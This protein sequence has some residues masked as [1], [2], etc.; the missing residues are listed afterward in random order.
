[1]PTNNQ[2]AAVDSQPTDNTPSAITNWHNLYAGLDGLDGR[3]DPQQAQAIKLLDSDPNPQEARARVIN[4]NRLSEQLK[5]MDPEM[6]RNNWQ[7]VKDAYVKHAFGSNLK[8]VDDVTLYNMIAEQMKAERAPKQGQEEQSYG[9]IRSPT[10]WEKISNGFDL[11]T[12]NLFHPA[13]KP[14]MIHAE[15][16]KSD[17]SDI[18]DLLGNMVGQTVLNPGNVLTGAMLTEVNVAGSARRVLPEA[19]HAALRRFFTAQMIGQT[20]IAA[21]GVTKEWMNPN[22]SGAQAT[23][24][25]IGLAVGGVM[26][27][28]GV[29]AEFVPKEASVPVVQGIKD[30]PAREAANSV[31]SYASQT[32]TPE[33]QMAF[34]VTADNFHEMDPTP[35]VEPKPVA[36]HAEPLGQIMVEM[37]QRIDSGEAAR[38]GELN[39]PVPAGEQPIVQPTQEMA[40]QMVPNETPAESTSGGTQIQESRVVAEPT[41]SE[42]KI[43][44]EE[45]SKRATAKSAIGEDP[46]TLKQRINANLGQMA[47]TMDTKASLRE[48]YKG[49]EKA[50]N[51]ALKEGIK[52]GKEAAYKDII[53]SQK[54]TVKQII[55]NNLNQIS[56]MMN[57]KLAMKE[58]YKGQEL[59]ARK[60]EVFTAEKYREMDAQSRADAE[61]IKKSLVETV[62]ELP[63]SE[64]GKF[65]QM[66]ADTIRRPAIGRDPEGLYR[67][68][69]QT[70]F[71]ILNHLEYV[72]KNMLIDDLRDSIN[73]SLESKQIDVTYKKRIEDV[74][75]RITF[76]NLQDTTKNR[77]QGTLD[78]IKGK[79]EEHGVPN[80]V[81]NQVEQLFKIPAKD[82]PVNVLEGMQD[83]VELLANLGKANLKSRKL[84]YDFEKNEWTDVLKKGESTPFNSAVKEVAPGQDLSFAE[85]FR[86]NAGNKLRKAGEVASQLDI[87]LLGRDVGFDMLDGNAGYKGSLNKT[88]GRKFDSNYQNAMEYRKSFGSVLQP[89][90]DA[91]EFNQAEREQMQIYAEASQEG[92]RQHLLDSGLT[93]EQIEDVI[94]NI[95]PKQR[96]LVEATRELGDKYIFPAIEKLM[97]DEYNLSVEK[98]KN[99]SP[100]YRDHSLIESKPEDAKVKASSKGV[101]EFDDL[102]IFNDIQKDFRPLTTKT[103]QGMTKSRVEGAKGAIKMDFIDNWNRHINQVSHLLANQRD[104]KMGGEIVRSDFFKQKYGDLGRDYMLNFLDTIARQDNVYSN[105]RIGWIDAL[106]KRTSVGVLGL[107]LT[108]QLKH[109][110]NLAL[111]S[112]EVRPDFLIEGIKESLTPN[113]W[114]FVNNNFAEVAQRYGGEPAIADLNDKTTWQ[115]IQKGSFF[116]ERGLDST[117]ARAT[118]LGKYM[119]ELHKQGLDYKLYQEHPIDTMSDAWNNAVLTSR[120]VVTS[121]LP[122]DVPQAISRGAVF[123]NQMSLSKAF[124]QY[125][126]TMLRQ[127][128]YMR[129]DILDLGLRNLDVGK[130]M[131]G[132]LA[133]TAVVAG[134]TYLVRKNR[135]LLRQLANAPEQTSDKDK[136]F[137]QEMFNETFRR[138]PFAGNLL[139]M[140]YGDTGIPVESTIKD[141]FQ[142]AIQTA[143]DVNKYGRPL[144]EK[145]RQA[146]LAQFIGGVGQAAGIP[147]A[148]T[149]ASY[150]RSKA[151]SQRSVDTSYLDYKG[152]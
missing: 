27:G 127:W 85:R 21:P 53:E 104:L 129:H 103:E 76:S 37:Q 145:E 29:A 49:Q 102:S 144:S 65:T 16:V 78:Y 6:I 9:V 95:T 117:I 112:V 81:L 20:G 149:A 38:A 113:G 26:A 139:S 93:N 89:V 106:T 41:T 111:A 98:V 131:A 148:G 74:M 17:W 55:Q 132:T 15:G 83:K 124:F 123:N 79:G 5:T 43:A 87:N 121:P 71:R 40:A 69:I 101:V 77:L 126:N 8:N 36:N 135:E 25:T 47:G 73:K 39:G 59:A 23:A 97:R 88:F 67:R 140:Q 84:Q 44:Q 100:R 96:A 133:L 141:I 31:N 68:A 82:L 10:A 108:S 19:Y 3:L 107:R 125:Q 63:V 33:A 11:Y 137:E 86:L 60:A 128:G 134:D 152:K 70:N 105:T 28:F 35:S 118:V 119:Q 75:K 99:Y 80:Y 7:G 120:K 72:R 114:D 122:K 110:P 14:R 136:S 52:I 109:L 58:F 115:K 146:N 142:P 54:P 147:G 62:N 4:Q 116:L 56:G 34:E 24:D 57:N 91:H 22:V 32:P 143:R 130:A 18:P 61:A 2:T 50:A 151:L 30:K 12:H 150:L 90:L 46:K 51:I 64:R 138:V 92:G 94:R 13:L 42:E 66:I 45:Q 48:F 1:M